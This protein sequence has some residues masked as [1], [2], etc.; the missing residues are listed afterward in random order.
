MTVR[1][2]S[3]KTVTEIPMVHC[4]DLI[5]GK[6]NSILD[7]YINNENFNPYD[8]IYRTPR[9]FICPDVNQLRVQG[10]WAS[11]TFS[12]VEITFKGCD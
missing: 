5:V 1:G 4:N 12:Y 9:E 3:R 10:Q 7:G 6:T 2:D 11:K 8:T